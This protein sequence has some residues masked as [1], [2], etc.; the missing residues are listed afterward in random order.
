M[1]SIEWTSKSG[2]LAPRITPYQN[3]SLDPA[4]CVFHYGFEC[5]EGMKAY[6]AADDSIRLFRPDKN[7]ARFNSSA[8]RIALPT[9]AGEEL[10]ALIKQLV[11]LEKRFIPQLV[12]LTLVL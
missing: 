2:W 6:R 1:L 8:K 7:M 9:F 5:F 11:G 4:T 3:L 10:I 12:D